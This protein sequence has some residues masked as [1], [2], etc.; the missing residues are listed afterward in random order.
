MNLGKKGVRK[1]LRDLDSHSVMLGNKAGVSALRA[2]LFLITAVIVMGVMLGFGAY[3]GI[4]ASAPDIE[5]VNIMPLGQATMIYDSDNNLIQQ[6]NSSEG[7][8]ISVSIQEIPEDM[9]HAI[10]AIEDSR[11]YTHNGV[12]P[13]GMLRAVAVAISTGLRRTEGASTITQQLLKNNVFTNWTSENK[14]QGIKRKLQEQYLAVKL[15]ASLAAQGNDPKGVILENYLNTVNFGSGCYGIQTASQKYFGK[16]SSQLSLSECAVLAAIPQ[17]PTKWNPIRHPEN[18]A[19]RREKVL[20][21]MRT[22]E[23]ITEE[24]YQEALADPVYDRIA[25]HS[26][27]TITEE[28]YSY[29]VDE[30]IVQLKKDLMQQK[31]YTPVQA[32]NAIYSGGLRIY[33]T[34]DSQ[35]Q[36]IMDEEFCNEENYPGRVTVALDWAMTVENQEGELQN[37]SREMLQLYFRDTED[38]DFDLLFDTEEEAVSYIDRY[39]QAVVGPTDTVVAEWHT[40]TPQPQAAMTVLDQTNSY[41]RGIVGGRGEKTASL[42]LNRATDSYRQ[43]GSTFK[44]LSTYGPALDLGVITLS[45]VYADEPYN[46]SD[47]SPIHNADNAFHGDVTVRTAIQNS[48]NIPAIKVLDQITPQTGMNKLLD[49]GFE[50]LIDSPEWDVIQPLALG[51]VTNGVSNLELTAAYAAIANHGEYISPTFYTRV[52]NASGEVILEPQQFTNTVFKDSTAYLLTSAMLDVVKQGTGVEYQ[53]NNMTVAGKTGTTTSY[54]DLVFAGFTPYYTSAIWAGCDVSLELPEEYRNYHK[55]LWTKI[56]N[57]IDEV[58]QLPDKTFEMPSSVKI[59]TICPK[60]GLLA[61]EGCERVMEYYDQFNRPSETCRACKPVP[62]PTPTPSATPS[63]TPTPTATPTPEPEENPEGNPEENPDAPP[64]EEPAQEGE[65]PQA[66]AL[67]EP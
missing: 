13:Q 44:I 24:Q 32:N 16:P 21:D 38:P 7:N 25:V 17:N 56:M 23:Y 42:T 31:G 43:P 45:S 19:E 47:G 53:L 15:E 6:L 49:L 50:K 67:E 3:K 28:P 63:A 1:R 46:Y 64:P 8:R 34:Q 22:Q 48:F 29:F 18:N 4:I 57:R 5:D 61:G 59:E 41:V 65:V 40:C 39:R 55:G 60:T 62:T 51:G 26:E 10:V 14:I 2:A 36:A 35:I 11:F 33:T 30:L 9:Q 58:K 37:Y 27:T 54:R 12:D 20:R 52:E 66:Y